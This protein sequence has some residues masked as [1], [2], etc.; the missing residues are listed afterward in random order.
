MEPITRCGK[1]TEPSL[2]ADEYASAP[3]WPAVPGAIPRPSR[4]VLGGR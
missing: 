2:A 1:T 4:D 3:P